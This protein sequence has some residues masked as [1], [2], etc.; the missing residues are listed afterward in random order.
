MKH[1]KLV[2]RISIIVGL[3]VAL[4]LATSVSDHLAGDSSL[5]AVQV[6]PA[7]VQRG[8]YLA[9]LGDCA[10]CHSMP[11]RPPF[12]G[13][14]AMHIPI[15]TIYTT[16]IT[17]DTVDGIGNDSLDDFDRALRFGVSRGHTLYPAMPY[18]SYSRLRPE[19]VQ[20]LYAYFKYG[21]MPSATP[22]VANDVTFPLSLRFPLTM[23]RW[24]FAPKPAPFTPPVGMD[25]QVA[26]GAY[27]VEGLG[28][29]GEC[30]TPRG[31][32]MQVKAQTAADGA[33]FLA[34][35]RVDNWFA[36]SLRSIDVQG[37]LHDWSET[38]LA[39]FLRSGASNG[40][41]AFGS[42]S[43]VIAHSTQYMT[44][45]DAQDTARFLKSLD[46]AS[47]SPA[48]TYDGTT[49]QALRNGDASQRGAMIYL[50]NCAACHR[51]DGTGYDRVF[52]RLAGNPAVTADDPTSTISIV[53]AGSRTVWTHPAPAQFQMPSFAW[54][55]SN[56]EVADVA[57]FVRGSWGNHAGAVDVKT[58]QALRT[59]AVPSDGIDAPTTDRTTPS[60]FLLSKATASSP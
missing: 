36:P 24:A 39:S 20:A 9:K 23:W 37:T 32:A 27:F 43:D 51:P 14:L 7:L 53:L 34:G 18:P 22:N 12:T 29:C 56:Q 6:T 17:F 11:G 55:L 19:D 28:H 58:V 57:T 45:S 15:G 26:N 44:A 40:G 10:A 1:R 49:D 46:P 42:M 48:F 25:P 38:G 16:N 41:I 5:R 2:T 59:Q 50:D 31:L 52:P 54:R 35:A 8:A 3:G 60:H 4:L 47:A 13:G 21:V 33:S 30:H